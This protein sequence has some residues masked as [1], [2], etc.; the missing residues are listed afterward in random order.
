MLHDVLERYNIIYKCN[1][2][3]AL[4]QR[5]TNLG[6]EVY[7][8]EIGGKIN[9]YWT[10]RGRR[11]IYDFLTRHNIFPSQDNTHEIK[12]LQCGKQIV[13]TII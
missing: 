13:A 9:M 3:Y 8:N 10:E 1:G 6:Y 2:T 11:F 5:F 12:K 4:N 7:K